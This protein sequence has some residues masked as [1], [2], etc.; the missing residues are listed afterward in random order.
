MNN[1]RL[2]LLLLTLVGLTS[3][4]QPGSTL[5]NELR[6]RE[7]ELKQYMEQLENAEAA[8]NSLLSQLKDA[9]H[10]QVQAFLPRYLLKI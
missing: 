7:K 8:R 3:G 6:E 1:F 10:E 4:S 2:H 5:A 9:L